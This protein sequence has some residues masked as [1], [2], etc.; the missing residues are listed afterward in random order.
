M[1]RSA[2]A[3][4]PRG[5]ISWPAYTAAL[6]LGLA[7]VA[8]TFP[9]WAV[10][11]LLPPGA[12]WGADPA[13]QIVAQRY[14]LAQPWH[15][16]PLHV[17]GLM[18]PWGINLAFADGIPLA[19]LIAKAL[20]PVLPPFDQVATIWLAV[21]WVLQPVAAVFALR[22][23]GER[24]M[25]PAICIAILAL[26]QPCFLARLHHTTLS[27]HFTLLFLLGCY[28][29]ATNSQ[30]RYIG[31]ACAGAALLML[32]HPYFLFMGLA[33]PAAITATLLLRRDL[34]W[35]LAAGSLAGT[36]IAVVAAAWALGLTHGASAGVYGFHTLNLAGFFYPAGSGLLPGFPF[37]AEDATG[38]Q[39]EG[40]AYLG[41]GL[42]LLLAVAAAQPRHMRA[43]LRP[44][45]GLILACAV[46]TA[47]A[48][49]NRVFLFHTQILHLHAPTD[50]LNS[51]RASGRFV[52]VITYTILVG[53]VAVVARAH[54]RLAL[55]ILPAAACLAL[56]DAR[57]L[58]NWDRHLMS[59]RAAFMFDADEL[60]HVL[61]GHATLTVL[62]PQGCVSGFD[63]G[64]MQPLWL[65]ADTLMPTN[66]AYV[67]RIQHRPSC[68][69]AAALAHTPRPG[70][71][72]LV[73]P[74][75]L[76]LASQSP[77]A[78]LCRQIGA[79]AACSAN[80]PALAGLPPITGEIPIPPP[81]Q[82]WQQGGADVL[83]AFFTT[84]QRNAYKKN[85][86]YAFCNGVLI[87]SCST[88]PAI[89]SAG[90]GLLK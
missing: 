52:W 72:I 39:E 27:A 54:P 10:F 57:M 50:M 44:H 66:T 75:F 12:P 68:D 61:H 67:A 65:A 85:T 32:V 4:K 17:D 20:R 60:R 41:V 1:P 13:T 35:R 26:C 48:L 87:S 11:G 2:Q 63:I 55:A 70:E 46:L 31:V 40:Y 25:L 5:A 83:S 19:S 81:K 84:R 49:S 76:A 89:A 28:L 21:C 71:L 15:W 53:A 74:G 43:A 88:S 45:G 33:F 18:Q 58:W 86:P 78:S 22:G 82:W 77:D 42:L 36:I 8:V 37:A 34:L 73:Q 56:L 16:P 80:Q 59:D 90:T 69:V 79:Y 14:F 38:G 3:A 29:R 62:P 6:V 64:V 24:R 23:A 30:P 51:F 7:A 9:H 47:L